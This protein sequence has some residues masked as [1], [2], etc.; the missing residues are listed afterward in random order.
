MRLRSDDDLTA[1]FW[2]QKKRVVFPLVRVARVFDDGVAS[3]YEEGIATQCEAWMLAVVDEE[4]SYRGVAKLREHLN[5]LAVFSP[6]PHGA[7]V[8]VSHL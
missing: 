1:S 4:F 2:L 5:E 8:D 7:L 3:L 6:L